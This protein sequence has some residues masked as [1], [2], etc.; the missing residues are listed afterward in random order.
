MKVFETLMKKYPDNAVSSFSKEKILDIKKQMIESLSHMN[1][2]GDAT[3]FTQGTFAHVIGTMFYYKNNP[4]S[5][6]VEL[7]SKRQLL[8]SLVENLGYFIHAYEHKDIVYAI[9][10]L[11]RFLDALILVEY[12]EE[13]DDDTTA[14]LQELKNLAGFIKSKV[15][16]LSN[17]EMYDKLKTTPEYK[18]RLAKFEPFKETPEIN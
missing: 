3:Y 12:L 10:Y 6:K 7:L 5:E 9:K 13:I 11:E 1:Y 8:H 14:K 15:R 18:D 17:K 4:N 16:N 2:Y